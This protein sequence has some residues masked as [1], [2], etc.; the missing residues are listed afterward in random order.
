[1]AFRRFMI[2]H[3]QI[4][5][6]YMLHQAADVKEYPSYGLNCKLPNHTGSLVIFLLFCLDENLENELFY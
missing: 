1:M 2:R 6:I 5:G 4:L 3:Y